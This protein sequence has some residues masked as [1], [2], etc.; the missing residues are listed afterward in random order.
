MQKAESPF[1]ILTEKTY[2]DPVCGMS[3]T[4]EK[5]A[6]TYEYKGEHYY[7]CALSCLKKFQADPEKYLNPKPAA[8]ADGAGK[9][10]C[11]MHPE[12]IQDGPGTCP[13]CGMALEPLEVTHEEQANPELADMRRRL[14]WSA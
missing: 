11:P 7:F 13:K 4:K 2:R 6:G 9:Y 8:A 10:T 5:A 3:V 1:Q 12:V 14:W